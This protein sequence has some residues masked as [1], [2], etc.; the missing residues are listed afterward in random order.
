MFFSSVTEI[1][2]TQ[3]VQEERFGLK[4]SNDYTIIKDEQNDI[5]FRNHLRIS[6]LFR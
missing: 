5:L 4:L 3:T 1:S 2:E 6:K